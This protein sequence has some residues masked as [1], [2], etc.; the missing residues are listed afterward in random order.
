MK[1]EFTSGGERVATLCEDLHQVVGQ[2]TA[3][4]VQ[5]ED[6]VG[7]GIALVD[8]HSVGHTITRVEHDSG[9]TARGVQR[10]HSLD[11][12]VHGRCVEDL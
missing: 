8:W 4:Q 9:G 5:T 10:Q 1:L 2:V 11:G 12:D 3:G 6:G 7:Q